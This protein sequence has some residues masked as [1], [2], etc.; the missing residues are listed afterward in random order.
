[1]SKERQQQ[2]FLRGT[3]DMV[4]G[5]I[6]ASSPTQSLSIDPHTYPFIIEEP[7]QPNPPSSKTYPERL[8]ELLR[9]TKQ[10]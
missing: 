1:M 3:I 6:I 10:P 4:T 8:H 5:D 7:V 2:P 9:T